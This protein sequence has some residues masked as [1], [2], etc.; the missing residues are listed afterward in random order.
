M[1]KSGFKVIYFF[2]SVVLGLVYL[3]LIQVSIEDIKHPSKNS[4]K[5]TFIIDSKIDQNI[6]LHIGANRY[7]L[8]SVKSS[9]NSIKFPLK[10]MQWFEGI[11][12]QAILSLKS[13]ENLIEVTVNN[14]KRVYTPRVKEKLSNFD[15][16]VLFIL[17]GIPIFHLVFLLFVYLLNKLKMKNSSLSPIEST[18]DMKMPYLILFLILTGLIIRVI[19]F[20]KYGV[21]LFQHDWHGHIEFIKLLANDFTLP[22]SSK[23]LE[24]PQQPLYY[25]LTAGLYGL[26]SS[27]DMSERHVLQGVGYLSLL[28]G[29]VFVYYSYKLLSLLTREKWIVTV[30]MVFISLTP[31]LVYMSARINND[32]L[33]MALSVLSLFYIVK[34]YQAKFQTD[35][36]KALAVLSMLFMTKISA[37]PME[38]FLFVLLL[39]VYI[40]VNSQEDIALRGRVKKNLYIFSLVGVFLLTFT[41]LRVYLPIEESFHMVNSSANYPRQTIES[42]GVEYFTS[43]NIQTLFETGYSHV[44]G[45]DDIRYS[46]L[47]YQYGTMFFGEFNYSFFIERKEYIDLIMKGILLLGL[48]YVLGF[49]VYILQVYKRSFL[50]ILLFL[51]MTFNLALI[52]K[53]M[54]SY[55]AVCNTDFRYFVP[56]FVLFAFFFA[57][58]LFY[59]QENRYLD[60]PINLLIILLAL[61]KIGFF[62]RLLA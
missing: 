53:F 56:S 4:S 46:F 33:V 34:S 11:G 20:H 13:G 6:K 29:F 17:L 24:Y 19:Y 43:F 18:I 1:F 49:I 59:F 61:S 32:S 44:Y 51:L 28:S 5:F 52:L 36:Y 58:G 47:T 10:K 62:I 9:G 12:E 38:L 31:S 57:K 60:K 2:I 22:L 14:H 25:I 41:L 54:F 48:V 23:G 30:G 16:T 55:P 42:F 27:F 39:A 21:T 15:F 3:S 37:A 8:L 26:F 50:E 35:F 7:K 45:L 40:K